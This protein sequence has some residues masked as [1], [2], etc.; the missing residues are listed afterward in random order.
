MIGKDAYIE[1][2]QNVMM[3]VAAFFGFFPDKY[4]T[5]I[6]RFEDNMVRFNHHY[7]DFDSYFHIPVLLY[8]LIVLF[9]DLNTL[10]KAYS[11][12]VRYLWALVSVFGML[13]MGKNTYRARPVLSITLLLASNLIIMQGVFFNK[14]EEKVSKAK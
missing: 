8:M 2:I 12:I 1:N 11:T 6:W 13:M 9:T 5:E 4:I 10:K 14:W 7:E 3:P